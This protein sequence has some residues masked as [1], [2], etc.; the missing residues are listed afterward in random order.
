MSPVGKGARRCTTI[1]TAPPAIAPMYKLGAKMP[2]ALPDAYETMVAPSFRKHR[3][4]IVFNRRPPL[5][6]WSTYSY[7]T[8]MIAGE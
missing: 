1:P 6:A 7:P 8:P 3:I 2:P 5:S 4:T